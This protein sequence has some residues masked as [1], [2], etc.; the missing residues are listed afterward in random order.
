VVHDWSFTSAACIQYSAE[1]RQR[2]C[3]TVISQL[4]NL[5]C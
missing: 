5:P 2:L 3:L 1:N 4:A